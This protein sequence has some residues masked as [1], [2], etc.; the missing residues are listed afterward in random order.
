MC[1]LVMSLFLRDYIKM[2]IDQLSASNVLTYLQ[3]YSNHTVPGF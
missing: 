2:E 1:S 3:E